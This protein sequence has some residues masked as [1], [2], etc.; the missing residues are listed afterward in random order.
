MTKKESAKGPEEVSLFLFTISLESLFP[1]QSFPF[2]SSLFTCLHDFNTQCPWLKI[3]GGQVAE[4]TAQLNSRMWVLQSLAFIEELLL[5]PNT[6]R[7][8]RGELREAQL[9][10]P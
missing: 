10:L 8:G 5:D 4:S 7:G 3:S 6:L 2:V 1:L 9:L